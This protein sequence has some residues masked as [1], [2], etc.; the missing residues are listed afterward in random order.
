MK[1]VIIS[2]VRKN[3]IHLK[4]LTSSEDDRLA[5]PI[6]DKMTFFPLK[7]HELYQGKYEFFTKLQRKPD[8]Q[9]LV[10]KHNSWK[11]LCSMLIDNR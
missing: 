6:I 2:R 7:S 9:F 10:I 5:F 1:G 8:S 3:K 4:C 11:D